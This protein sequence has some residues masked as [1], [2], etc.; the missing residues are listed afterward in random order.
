MNSTEVNGDVSA[1]TPRQGLGGGGVE[2]ATPTT[3][4]PSKI[5]RETPLPLAPDN[6]G[7]GAPDNASRELTFRLVHRSLQ[8][9]PGQSAPR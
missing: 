7:I 2:K 9:W 1:H 3:H 8:L 6:A 5:F 4:A